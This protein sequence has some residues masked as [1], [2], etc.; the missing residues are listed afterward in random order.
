MTD[1]GKKVRTPLVLAAFGLLLGLNSAYLAFRNDPTLFYFGNVAL[2]LAIGLVVAFPFRSVI[3][4]SWP[5]LGVPARA[6]VAL[7]SG[8]GLLGVVLMFSGTTRPFR[9]ILYVHIAL[10]AA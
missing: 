5:S 7:F 10:A 3:R 9:P 8:A 1:R 4:A 2:H 6:A